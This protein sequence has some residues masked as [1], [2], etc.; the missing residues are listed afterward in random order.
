MFVHLLPNRCAY[1]VGTASKDRSYEFFS[2]T[3]R[4]FQ[5]EQLDTVTT[6]DPFGQFKNIVKEEAYM[7]VLISTIRDLVAVMSRLEW[8][9]LLLIADELIHSLATP[10]ISILRLSLQVHELLSSVM[11]FASCELLHA[12]VFVLQNPPRARSGQAQHRFEWTHDQAKSASSIF[13]YRYQIG[14]C[15]MATF[16]AR[17]G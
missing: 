5:V 8:L 17:T 1:S 13:L 14:I 16:K 2:R 15:I 3:P 11:T 7:I 4:N 12:T 10:E 9:E 6:S